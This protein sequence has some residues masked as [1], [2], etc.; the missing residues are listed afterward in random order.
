MEKAN[1]KEAVSVEQILEQEIKSLMY[2]AIGQDPA[3]VNCRFISKSDLAILIENVR[4]PLEDFLDSS[5]GPDVVYRYRK[6]MEIAI[7]QKIQR[8]VEG[9]MQRPI[10]HLSVTRKTETGWM[11]IFVFL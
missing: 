8:L 7:G 1:F 2:D 5:C 4:T 3:D 6:G 11:G 10:D 9:T